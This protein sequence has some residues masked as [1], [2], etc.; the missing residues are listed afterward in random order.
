MSLRRVASRHCQ[1]QYCS[2]E[3]HLATYPCSLPIATSPGDIG[4][5][6]MAANILAFTLPS[7]KQH[8]VPG[9]GALRQLADQRSMWEY[10]RF[11]YQDT[12][13]LR[14]GTLAGWIK[15]FG[16]STGTT[17]HLLFERRR[18]MS[19]F[20]VSFLSSPVAS[21]VVSMYVSIWCGVVLTCP[22]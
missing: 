3:Y 10:A 14:H 22:L 13:A 5:S 18:A 17:S 12:L 7:S 16:I 2:N 19:N 11:P 8:V 15:F 1:C 21:F 20:C 6:A 4:I 9:G